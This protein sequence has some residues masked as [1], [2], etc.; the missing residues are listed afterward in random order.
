MW[1]QL[2]KISSIERSSLNRFIV[3]LREELSLLEE[4]LLRIDFK[5][6]YQKPLRVYKMLESKYGC[7]LEISLRQLRILESLASF[8]AW[9]I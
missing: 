3:T 1:P 4:L 8:C 9:K 7:S 5:M 2:R 6:M